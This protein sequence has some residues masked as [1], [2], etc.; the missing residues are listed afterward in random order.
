MKKNYSC[1]NKQEE[2]LG[3]AGEFG[4]AGRMFRQT[5]FQ[6]RFWR[7]VILLK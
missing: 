1:C 6:R 5:Y 4:F 2:E 3:S 7:K